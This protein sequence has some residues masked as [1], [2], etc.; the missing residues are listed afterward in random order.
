MPEHLPKASPRVFSALLGR[1]ALLS[2]LCGGA[3]ATSLAKT[4]I[5]KTERV[6]TLASQPYSPA[7]GTLPDASRWP[8]WAPTPETTRRKLA[9]LRHQAISLRQF[10]AT[11]DG[12][13]DDTPA[14]VRAL[15][16][17]VHALLVDGPARVTGTICVDRPLAIFGSGAGPHLVW[18]GMPR[19][20]IFTVRRQDNDPALF[21][22]DVALAGLHAVRAD[23]Q[24]PGG[25][26]VRAINVRGLTIADCRMMRMSLAYVSHARMSAYDRTKGS[27]TVD[28][29]VLA[30]F[31]ASDVNDLNEDIAILGNEV[32]YGTYMGSIIRFNFARRVLVQGNKGRFARISW[33]GGGAKRL[34]GGMPQF[35]RRVR[36]V[37]IADNTISNVNGGIYGNNG[38]SIA[39]VRN[40]VSDTTDVGIDFEGCIDCIATLNH[41]RNAGNFVYSA[42]YMARNV[43][44]ERN[45]GE[46]DGSA[47][48]IN[49]RLGSDPIGT[50][51]GVCLA[52]L[53]GAGFANTPDV[54]DVTFADNTFVFSG[55][56][57][58]G[59]CLSGAFNRLAFIGNTMRNVVCDISTRTG[60]AVILSG[61][62]LNFD[63][64]A[65]NPVTMLAASAAKG[66][67]SDNIV[68]IE[69]AQP[70]GSV[71]IAYAFPGNGP[72][73]IALT[74]NLVQGAHPL[75]IAVA[76][77]GARLSGNRGAPVRTG[78]ISGATVLIPKFSE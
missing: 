23:G 62:R 18:D 39:V 67:I 35:L 6:R 5:A 26:L 78:A 50:P 7:S 34:Q 66:Q 16:A 3:I 28:P 22:H 73:D 71:A 10:G 63:K 58:L 65:T 56:D 76:A 51:R 75:P 54:I 47:A 55:H 31:S 69:A 17:G 27:E 37:Y 46:Q 59:R 32:D 45:Y 21:V 60:E 44:F 57:G 30:G 2:G 12:K 33:W 1:R 36:D 48:D 74:N 61:N 25:M 64:S 53:R 19:D 20:A 49:D 77:S 14:F 41:C 70:A 11:L 4:G 8:S 29:A 72:T 13:S 9:V 43:R 52:A 68:T 40:M 42:F 15:A 24:A 38:Q